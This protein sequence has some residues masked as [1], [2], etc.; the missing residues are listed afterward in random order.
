MNTKYDIGDVLVIYD[1]YNERRM[2]SDV[3]EIH[4]DAQTGVRYVFS[5]YVN[6][7]PLTVLEQADDCSVYRIVD[8]ICTLNT[9]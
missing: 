8:K 7:K 3:V 1:G 2:A 4:A 9:I 6:G 5:C